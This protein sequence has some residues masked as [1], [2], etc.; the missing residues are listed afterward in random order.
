LAEG[1]LWCSDSGSCEATQDP[2]C[3]SSN[4]VT[5]SCPSTFWDNL[6]PTEKGLSVGAIAGIVIASI[7]GLVIFVTG[8]KK[9]YDYYMSKR[10]NLDMAAKNPLYTDNGRS[11]NNPFYETPSAHH[12]EL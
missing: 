2:P 7:I 5:G 3:S 9:G 6:T 4:Q 11:G 10:G 1:C 12:A 8:G